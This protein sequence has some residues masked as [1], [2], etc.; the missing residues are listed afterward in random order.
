VLTIDG[1]MTGGIALGGDCVV[2]NVGGDLGDALGDTV[3]AASFG[4]V[5]VGGNLVGTLRATTGDIAD[6][7]VIGHVLG[8][9]ETQVGD[10]GTAD[11]NGN[12]SGTVSSAG[13]ITRLDVGQDLSGTV[14]AVDEI[15]T[16]LVVTT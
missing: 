2:L 5:N 13:A 15:G 3:E 1:D 7:G 10:I 4:D 9:I 8:T 14:A 16:V 6:V 11:I 12:L